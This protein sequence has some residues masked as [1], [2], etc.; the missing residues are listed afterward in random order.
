MKRCYLVRHAQTVWNGEN[1]IQGHSDVPLSP[2]G[3]QQ[4]ER[5]GMCFASRHVQGIFTSALQRSRQTAEAIAAGNGH[6]V[7]PVVERDLAEIYLGAWEGLT[8]DEVDARFQKAYQQWRTLP[9]SVVI[10]DAEPLGAFKERVRTVMGRLLAGLGDGEHVIVS[11]GG[12]IAVLLADLLSAD[13]DVTI[14]RLRLDNAGITAVEYGAG[15]PHVM[16]VNSTTHLETLSPAA[17][18]TWF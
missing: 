18:T 1:R 7:T 17:G 11:H 6:S 3:I 13:Y 16:W 10:P 2:L 14:R 9:S 4:A 5:L 15:A 12:V 8:P